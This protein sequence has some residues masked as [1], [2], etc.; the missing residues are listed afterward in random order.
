MA[1]N[2]AIS[3]SR[4]AAV[5][6]LMDS[7]GRGQPLHNFPAHPCVV[8][9][10]IQ[11]KT[12]A[13]EIVYGVLRNLLRLDYLVK[14]HSNTKFERIDP[15]VLWILRISLYQLE[16]MSCPDYAVVNDA[17]A[18][19]G[20]FRK[21]SA[22]GFINGLL[23]AFLRKRIPL[24]AGNSA[25]SLAV[26]YSHPEWLVKRYLARH[27]TKPARK[28]MSLNNMPPEPY[29]RINPGR[30]SRDEFIRSLDLEGLEWQDYPQLPGCV[31][32]FS[33]GFNRHRLYREGACFYMDF[34]SQ[35]VASVVEA[36]PGMRVGDFCAAPGGKS[37]ILASRIGREGVVFASDVSR[38]RLEQMKKRMRHYG[39]DNCHLTCADLEASPPPFK[40]IDSC[41]L[42]VPCS[43]LGTIRS[44]PEIRWLLV[45]ADLL[46]HQARQS[47]ILHNCFRMLERGQRLYYSTCSSEP[48]ENQEVIEGL[49]RNE[50]SAELAGEPFNT[51]DDQLQGEGYFLAEIRRR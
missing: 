5:R 24:P 26:R 12:S 16:F 33:R 41:L 42:D 30:I 13:S 27:G 31:K 50:P 11:D 49:L 23:R 8:S 21:S 48:E 46:K 10:G 3:P 6:V 7:L 17:V 14:S 45:E 19:A 38:S 39:I 47:A 2:T 22:S 40:G 1:E 51:L 25:A 9:L 34:G 44:N 32:V 36:E 18:M 29:L 15:E 43:G 28:L 35:L 20:H 37:F 4:L